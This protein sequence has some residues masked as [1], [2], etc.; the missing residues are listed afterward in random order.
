MTIKA[1]DMVVYGGVRQ[2]VMGVNSQG[3]VRL[4]KRFPIAWFDTHSMTLVEPHIP[5]DIKPGDVVRI[6][7]IPEEEQYFWDN[8]NKPLEGDIFRVDEVTHHSMCG[9]LIYI[10]VDGRRHLFM[11]PYVEKI[12][13]YDII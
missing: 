12:S 5:K 7:D 3:L 1:G 4:S 2:R 10:R 13:D 8:A 9:P 6:L 11:E